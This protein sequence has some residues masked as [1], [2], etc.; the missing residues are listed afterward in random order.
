MY[1][2]YVYIDINIHIYIDSHKMV[3]F[4]SPFPIGSRS[5]GFSPHGLQRHL[6]VVIFALPLFLLQMILG[7]GLKNMSY[8]EAWLNGMVVVTARISPWMMIE[9]QRMEWRYNP[10]QSIGSSVWT[11]AI[12]M[13]LWGNLDTKMFYSWGAGDRFLSCGIV[14]NGTSK[15]PWCADV[16]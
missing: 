12:S 10:N 7:T 11:C 5:H 9:H 14:G 16:L 13:V 4:I 1:N 2:I 15:L 3:A 6:R 8:M